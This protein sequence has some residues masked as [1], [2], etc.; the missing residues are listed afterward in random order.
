MAAPSTTKWPASCSCLSGTLRLV[1]YS[2]PLFSHP[3][4][5]PTCAGK[6]L[7]AEQLDIRIGHNDL[8]GVL[9]LYDP[10]PGMSA[11]TLLV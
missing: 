2:T 4:K 7:R 8:Y 11:L 5:H 3:E 9:R 1:I 6:R 10:V